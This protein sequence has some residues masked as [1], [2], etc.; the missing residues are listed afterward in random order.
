MAKKKNTKNFGDVIRAKLASNPELAK[1]VEEQSFNADIAQQVHDLRKEVGLTQQQLAE[2]A[3]TY[4]SVISRIEDADYDGHSLAL[5][6]KI[7]RALKRKLKV[8]FCA[9]P[10]YCDAE[11]TEFDLNW[12]LPAEWQTTIDAVKMIPIAQSAMKIPVA[13]PPASG[14]LEFSF[15]RSVTGNSLVKV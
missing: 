3:E 15:T 13:Q 1:A 11:I 7:A 10:V 8:D 4:Q 9:Q 6:K 12:S 14:A 2:L 5:L